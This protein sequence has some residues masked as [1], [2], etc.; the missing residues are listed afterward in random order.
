MAEVAYD[1]LIPGFPARSSR[2]FLG[3]STV[4]L[5]HAGGIPVLVDTGGQG[6]R[7]GLLAALAARGLAPGDIRLV[8]LSHLH[9]DHIANIECFPG[10]E[11]V[12]HQDELA[13]YQ[14]QRHRDSALP[15][16]QIEAMLARSRLQLINGE[17][18]VLPGVTLLR[19]PGHTGGHCSVMFNAEGR[20]VMLAQDAIKHRGEALAGEPDAAFDLGRARQ[21]IRRIMA[22]ADVVV[23]GHD[24]PLALEAGRLVE[25][26]RVRVELTVGPAGR[27]HSLEV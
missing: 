2:G 25:A 15:V 12:V 27:K 10:A 26:D 22:L 7:L 16:F 1:I 14:E 24:G 4:T 17:L 3:W 11:L 19:T 23:P 18:E 5:L 13:Y 6:D 9:F 20:T 21:S 8:I